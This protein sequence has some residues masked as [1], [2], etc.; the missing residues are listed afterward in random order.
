MMKNPIKRSTF[1]LALAILLLA[2]GIVLAQ[3]GGGYDL[4]WWTVDSGGGAVS[5][6]SYTLAGTVGQPEPGPSLTGG[7]YTLYSGFWPGAGAEAPACPVPLTGV[8]V[9]G[10]S[11]GDTGQTLLFT[12][13]PQPGNA[14]APVAYTWSSDGLISG[15]GTSQASYRW[16][17]A[18]SKNVQV[19]AQNCGGAPHVDSQPV[20]IS[21]ACPKPIVDV[22]ITG[23]DAGYTNVNYDFTASPDPSNATAPLTY[24]WSSDGLVSGQGTVNATYSWSITGAHALSVTAENC[25]GSVNETH[26]ITL[27]AQQTCTDSLASVTI[28]GPTTG[29]KDT[30]Y[31]FTATV[32]PPNATE[33]IAYTW[34][35]SGLVDGQST[36]NATYRWSQSGEYQITVSAGNCGGS[37]NDSHTIEIGIKYVYLPLVLRNH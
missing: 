15:Q 30:D 18:G 12:A 27:S 32:Q 1:L 3:T 11:S 24:T 35:S 4:S 23:L 6:S 2:G 22:S 19:T 10:P 5:G 31:V 29:D 25:G 26:N 13:S 21:L 36:A 34:S 33:P 9:S 28:G 14:T 16:T 37:K 20:S 17:S 8:S 7:N